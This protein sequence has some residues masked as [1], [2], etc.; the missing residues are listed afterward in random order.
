MCK[1]GK[2]ELLIMPEW[3]IDSFD[4]KNNSSEYAFDSSGNKCVYIDQ[5]LVPLIKKLWSQE[6]HTAGCCCGHGSYPVVSLD[7]DGE[8]W[9]LIKVSHPKYEHRMQVENRM[10][11]MIEKYLGKEQKDII[12]NKLWNIDDN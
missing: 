7:I 4:E 8:E 1:D 9:T 12:Y 10:L 5:C 11:D 2:Q 6:Y 3:L